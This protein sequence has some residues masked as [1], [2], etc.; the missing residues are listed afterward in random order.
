MRCIDE[1]CNICPKSG[2]IYQECEDGYFLEGSFCKIK[3]ADENCNTCYEDA[4]ICSECKNS[5][6]LY[7]GKCALSSG[8]CHNIFKNCKYCLND[9]G[10]IEY[11]EDYEIDNKK[12]KIK[13]KSYILY[14]IIVIIIIFVII[15]N[16]LFLTYPNP[17]SPIPIFN[18]KI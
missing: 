9:E 2:L 1:N 13:E 18:F 14:V 3:C 6:I 4:S 8:N 17:Q 12:C 16:I 7:N 11:N 5:T 15:A 10:C